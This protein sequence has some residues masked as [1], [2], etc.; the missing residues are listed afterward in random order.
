MKNNLLDVDNNFDKNIG[1]G[2]ERI[3][4]SDFSVKGD[5]G[6]IFFSAW[7]LDNEVK[8]MSWGSGNARVGWL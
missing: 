8:G 7:K 1:K 6:N 5:G 4:V 3:S 2:R